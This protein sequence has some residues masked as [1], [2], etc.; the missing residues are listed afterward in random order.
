MFSNGNMQINKLSTRLDGNVSI[1]DDFQQWCG[2][3]TWWAKLNL[4]E[5]I[6]IRS[7]YWLN[8]LNATANQYPN[9]CDKFNWHNVWQTDLQVINVIWAHDRHI[10]NLTDRLVVNRFEMH[11]KEKRV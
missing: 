11:L 3:L 2:K 7:V 8:Y 9:D 1:L 10:Y 6:N 4:I 5:H